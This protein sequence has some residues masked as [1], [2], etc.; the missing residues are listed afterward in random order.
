MFP[1]K[2]VDRKSLSWPFKILIDSFSPNSKLNFKS[3]RDF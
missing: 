1:I 2:K 3:E